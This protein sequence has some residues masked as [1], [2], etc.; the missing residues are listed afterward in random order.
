VSFKSLTGEEKF[1][2]VIER[3]TFFFQN[4]EFEEN[5]EAYISS[6]V[7]LLLLLQRDL[8]GRSSDVK[9]R[10]LVDFIMDKQDG[11]SAV[12]ALWGISEEFLLRLVTFIRSVKDKDLDK[13]VNKGS[14]PR[15]VLEREWNKN[16]IFKLVRTKRRMA[17]GLVNLL[18]EGFSVPILRESLPL[19]ELKK[20]NF[21][22]LDFS[23]EG[24]IDSI[25]RQAKRGSYKAQGE[26]DPATLIKRLLD[27]S[28]IPYEQNTIMPS[29]RRKLDFVIPSRIAPKV[30]VESSYELTTSSA[31]GD[32]A[33]TEIAVAGDIR[34]HHPR[35]S[36][37]G[38]VDGIGWYVRRNDLARLVVAFDTVFT[39]KQTELDR[40]L[41]Y[42]N[43][44]L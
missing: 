43:A 42:I 6:F 25:V 28:N 1:S 35:V 44:I 8:D 11:L 16:Y 38:F 21:T 36:F 34:V 31:M 40:F 20:L 3:N 2:I 7:N 14:F 26:N 4:E 15:A 13:L 41:D 22:K 19:F 17:E 32:K 9:K 33:K 39:F 18:F 37:V 5:W 24:L 29:I 27:R 30:I 10:V 23:I 12:L